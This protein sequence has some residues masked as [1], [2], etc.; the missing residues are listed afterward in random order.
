M[1]SDED[2]DLAL[3]ANVTNVWR[4]LALVVGKTMMQ[5]DS[6]DRRGLNDLYFWRRVTLLVEKGL[7]D[8][9]GELNQLRICEIKLTRKMNNV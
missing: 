3:M 8:Y 7:I 1:I 9:N 4:K 2:I 6:T 5:I